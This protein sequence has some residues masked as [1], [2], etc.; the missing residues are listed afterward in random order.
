MRRYFE[1]VLSHQ[2]WVW[3][4]L[5]LISVLS[6][7][8]LSRAV[9][10]STL[11]DLFFGDAPEYQE[12]LELGREFGNDEVVFIGIEESDPLAPKSLKSLEEA[13]QRIEADPDFESVQSVLS[14]QQI[15]SDEFDEV[16]IQSF[17]DAAQSLDARVVEGSLSESDAKLARMALMEE[18]RSDPL[19]GGLII[20]ADGQSHLLIV[21]LTVNPDRNPEQRPNLTGELVDILVDSG[22]NPDTIHVAG[23]PH[24]LIVMLEES[25]DTLTMVFPCMV[26]IMVGLVLGIFRRFAPVLVATGV[27]FLAVLWTMGFATE[28]ERNHSIMSTIIPGVVLVVAVSD[29]IHLWSAYL[30]ELRSGRSKHEAI[31]ESAADVGRACLWTSV[32]TFVGFV[33][34][35]LVP[36]PVFRL[37]GV[38]LGFGVAIALLLAMTLVPMILSKMDEPDLPPVGQGHRWERIIQGIVDVCARLSTRRPRT[39]LAVFGL[40]IVWIGVGLSR[41]QIETRFTERLDED[42]EYRQDAAW[43]AANFQGNQTIDVYI[44]APEPGDWERADHVQAMRALEN[45]IQALPQTD[46]VVSYTMVLESLME[47]VTGEKGLPTTDPQVAQLMLL[48][49]SDEDDSLSAMLNH[50]RDRLR[51]GV[52][53][54]VE[55]IR[56]IHM[57]AEDIETMGNESFAGI[58]GDKVEVEATGILSLVGWWVD[59]IL[60]G[61][62]NGLALSFILITVMMTLALRS[63]RAGLLSMIPNML[64]LLT[65]GAVLGW[66]TEGVDSDALVIGMMAIGIGVDDT[67]H[68]LVRYRTEAMRCKSRDEAV[69]RTFNFAGRAILITTLILSLGFL[70]FILSDYLST[71]YFGS[72]LPLALVVALLADLLWVP[73]L[74]QLGVFGFWRQ[75]S[76]G[77]ITTAVP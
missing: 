33:C 29:V 53:L 49:E 13:V 55:G 12:Y 72:L 71:W 60:E 74:A 44:S 48:L 63:F 21:S 1:F 27:S 4:V 41:F 54:N 66:T 37:M 68:F 6:A 76:T 67:I 36:T 8:S 7:V 64:P 16:E 23:Q 26:V 30:E 17:A 56:E 14:A 24:L 18:M 52:R 2:R 65:L 19:S 46:G 32:T 43:F 22:V 31:L 59:A 9:L 58:E 35:S 73:A 50:E 25:Y 69:R 62:K 77:S 70:P 39:I 38:V 3:L 57:L 10:G 47:V 45:R 61:Q 42:T 15:H 75:D 28:L 11:Q 51:A 34:L 20:S 5:V 40:L